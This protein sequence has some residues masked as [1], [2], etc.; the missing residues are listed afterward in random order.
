MKMDSGEANWVSYTQSSVLSD[1]IEEL[2]VDMS[3]WT[4]AF[5]S[6]QGQLGLQSLQT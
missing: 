6:A 3:L 4:H 1:L 5:T 2:F